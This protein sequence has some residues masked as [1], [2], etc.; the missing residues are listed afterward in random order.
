M[1]RNTILTTIGALI[2]AAS[3]YY[4]FT[5]RP[6]NPRDQ[7]NIEMQDMQV[8]RQALFDALASTIKALPEPPKDLKDAITKKY[9]YY[10]EFAF[11]KYA[12]SN[13]SSEVVDEMTV[14]F[15]TFI[16]AYVKEEGQWRSL[17]DGLKAQ[18]FKILPTK[19]LEI[20]LITIPRYSTIEE[21]FL[22]KGTAIPV[23]ELVLR[24]TDPFTNF[25]LGHPFI[26]YILCAIGVIT[27]LMICIT[28]ASLLVNEDPSK[29]ARETSIE[30]LATAL[31]V[32]N[33]VR[34]DNPEK[35]ER[36]LEQANKTHEKWLSEV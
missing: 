5:P 13:Q 33:W 31:A 18:S 9:D 6:T 28:M 29:K 21:T 20:L 14:H 23:R 16:S 2:V 8:A 11:S 3:T 10:S 26:T 19:S 12:V 1:L 27:I 24:Y 22:V 35:Y 36:V 17:A 7:I 15:G 30:S 4:F 34:V 25:F 32:I